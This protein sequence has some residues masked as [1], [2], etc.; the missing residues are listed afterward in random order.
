MPSKGLDFT[1][2]KSYLAKRLR[3][4]VHPDG[5]VVVTLPKRAAEHH[6]ARFVAQQADWILKKQAYWRAHP[7]P[8]ARFTAA[9]YKK[10][11][12]EARLRL[13]EIVERFARQY[14]FSYRA[15]TIRNQTSRWGSCSRTG[16]LSFN[17]K[18]IFMSPAVQE[19]VVV[20]ELCHLKEMNH[21]PKF[22]MLVS[23]II[24]D[25][26]ERR[27]ELRHLGVQYR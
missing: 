22:W 12:E 19:Y 7:Q 3:L 20:H 8:Q 16:T 6:A 10:Y 25:Y 14:G 9:D 24:P 11:K 21:S 17:Y 5:S 4:A 2:R 15:I 18:L 26:T 23:R 27:R 13:T 1:I